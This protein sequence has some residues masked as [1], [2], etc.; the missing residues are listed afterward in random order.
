MTIT[1][2]HPQSGLFT[3]DA[4]M[5]QHARTWAERVFG[6]LRAEQF[7]CW[8]THLPEDVQRAFSRDYKAAETRFRIERPDCE[9]DM[10]C[11]PTD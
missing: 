5:R 9:G 4:W 3:D 10:V 11:W 1:P 2:I 7:I 8:L 6:V